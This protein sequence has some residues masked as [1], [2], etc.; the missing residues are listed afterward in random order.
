M[1]CRV[2]AA[3]F[4][5]P[6]GQRR[7]MRLHA[8]QTANSSHC[9]GGRPGSNLVRGNGLNNCENRDSAS[10]GTFRQDQAGRIMGLGR[11]AGG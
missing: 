8:A 9:A 10:P 3:L 6:W 11:S 1:R 4:R 5:P 2:W 7:A